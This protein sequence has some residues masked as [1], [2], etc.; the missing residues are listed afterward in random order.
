[1]TQS[2]YKPT[3]IEISSTCC[4]PSPG[5]SGSSKIKAS[6]T[7][8]HIFSRPLPLVEELSNPACSRPTSKPSAQPTSTT[9]TKLNYQNIL[10]AATANR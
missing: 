3:G 4:K 6:R 7:R 2:V 8:E 1:M 5:R 10:S 9:L